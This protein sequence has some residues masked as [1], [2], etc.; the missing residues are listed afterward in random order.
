MNH[1]LGIHLSLV[2]PNRAHLA[3]PMP[4]N[5]EYNIDDKSACNKQHLMVDS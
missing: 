2:S 3:A 5:L 4:S 1:S